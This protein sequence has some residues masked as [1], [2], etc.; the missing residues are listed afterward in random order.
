MT[1]RARLLIFAA[2]VVFAVSGAGWYVFGVKRGQAAN[3]A[4]ASSSG[5]L[6]ALAAGPHLV[7]RS[8]APGAGY[9]QVALVPIAA[10]DGPRSFTPAACDRVYAVR[11]TAVCLVALR[12]LA[13]TYEAQTLGPQWTPTRTEPLPGLPSRARISRAGTLTSTT[14]FVYGDSYNAPGQFSTRT[15][16]S[17]TGG[18]GE[19]TDLEKFDLIVDGKPVTSTD[20]NLWGVTF[21]DDDRFYATAASGKKT[22]LVQGTLSGRKL[23]ALRTDVEC[24][25]LSPD[26]T[27]IAFK[28]RG[29]LPPGHWRLT[30]LNLATG[31]E[32]ALAETRSV[33]DQAEWRDDATVLYGL[34]RSGEGTASSDVWAVPA[35]GS[36]SPRVLVPNAWSP[37]VVR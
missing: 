18:G 4:V 1:V 21:V 7:F 20:R 26:G 22:W 15:L 30:V 19:P 33:D 16:V 13:T 10:A 28:K 27:R 14:T 35:D 36:G 37:A 2:V 23:T 34:P 29:D 8:T 31:A 11:G 9:G 17:R 32:T 12:G 6:A 24:P 5:E 25:S 3:H